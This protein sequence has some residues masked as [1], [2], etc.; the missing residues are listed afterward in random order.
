ME[1]SKLSG[2]KKPGIFVFR[3]LEFK[4]F[5]L[6]AGVASA[7]VGVYFVHL[8]LRQIAGLASCLIDVPNSH[9]QEKSF[10]TTGALNLDLL[11]LR[12]VRD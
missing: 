11:H 7:P 9:Q 5:L 10:R 1:N 6:A 8:D 2:D 12:Q 3:R 4:S